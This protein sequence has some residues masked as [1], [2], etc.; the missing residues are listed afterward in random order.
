MDFLINLN[1]NKN[2]LQNVRIQNLAKEP[3]SPVPG[4]MYFNTVDKT[5]YVW[6]GTEWRNALYVYTGETLT[7]AL[8]LKLDGITEG[9]TKVE[10]SGTNGYIKINGAETK[11][12][13]HPG[14]GTNPH[15]TTKKDLGLG[16]VENKSA[17]TILNELT[18][19]KIVEK[20]GFTPREIKVGTDAD[21]GTATGSKILYIATDTKKIWLDNAAN[22]WLQVGGQDTIAW[23]NVTGKPSTFTPP[24]ATETR[25]GGIKVGSGLSV[26]ADGTLSAGD[27]METYVVKTERFTAAE[28]QTTFTLA[29]GS[30]RT[31]AGL[32][33]VYIN[34]ARQSND[35]VTEVSTTQFRVPALAAGTVV[36]AEYVQIMDLDPYAAHASEHL[37]GG[38]DPIPLA[39][40]SADGLMSKEVFAS[41][42]EAL[43]ALTAHISDGSNPHVVTKSQVGLGNVDNTADKDKP[44]STA[45]KTALNGKLSTSLK[46]AKNGLAELDANGQVPASQLPSYVDDVIEGYLSGGKFYSDSGK[47]TEIAGETGKIY[48]DLTSRKTYRWSGTAYAVISET[49]ALGETSSTAYRG[50]RG[51]IAYDHSQ[52]THAR[53]DATK[54]AKSST[55]GNVLINGTETVVYTHPSTHEASMITQD[56]THRFVSDAEKNAWNARPKK[57]AVNVGDGSTTEIT[58]THGLGTQDVTVM[59]RETASPYNKVYCD[60]QIISTTQ[61]KLLFATAPATGA[62]RCIV[63]G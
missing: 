19:A 18:K 59:V 27:V 60:V 12:Y 1:L 26:T 24:I 57:Y 21:K 62:Y 58:V 53:T 7:A 52:S 44:V 38:T 29:K 40:E 47:T 9:A 30:Y 33:A 63:T 6:T 42:M 4:Q 5:L 15:G 50:D 51:K 10:A 22:T 56:A 37:T 41:A 14:S 2:E 23:E 54:T 35:I 61:V 20:L 32:L 45:V 3:A 8:K 17:A 13:T 28:N 46:G 43:W 16:N 39:T 48:V 49:I 31:G 36:L 11:V 55:N 34:G 25:L